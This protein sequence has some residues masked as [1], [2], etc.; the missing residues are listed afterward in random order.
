MNGLELC[1][2]IKQDVRTSH[3]PVVLLSAKT[4]LQ[5][6]LIGYKFHADAYCPKPF[7]NKIM[8][9]LLNSIITNRKRILQ[10]K[11]VS[12][13]KISEVST[14]STDDKIP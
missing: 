6:Y 5:D 7:D 3:I 13:I 8:K 2:R 14:T 1:E 4:T 9:E 10:Y 11:K 12:A